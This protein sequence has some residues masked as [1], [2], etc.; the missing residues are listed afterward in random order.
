MSIDPMALSNTLDKLPLDSSYTMQIVGYLVRIAT[1]NLVGLGGVYWA[2]K[3]MMLVEKS[4]GKN[5]LASCLILSWSCWMQ[6]V[7]WWEGYSWNAR[8]YYILTFTIV[9]FVPYVLV[10]WRL[11]DRV[12][13]YFDSKNFKDK[14]AP[15]NGDSK[16]PSKKKF[17]KVS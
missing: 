17:S 12:D 7:F 16:E 5:I 15:T 14:G 1:L 13:F 9:S 8:I 3:M 2:G 6:T 11:F 4:R 10:C